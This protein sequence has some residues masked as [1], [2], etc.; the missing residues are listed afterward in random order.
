[1]YGGKRKAL[2]A[3]QAH[4]DELLVL[5]SPMTKA[6]YAAIK[7]KNNRSGLPGVCRYVAVE[8][9]GGTTRARAYWIAFWT[10]SEGRPVHRKFSISKFGEEAAFSRAKAA[11]QQALAALV[12]FWGEG[13]RTLSPDGGLAS[14]AEN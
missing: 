10:T 7:R 8:T 3:A 12:G 5:H 1:M 11:R 14:D 6:E 13:A 9:L 4:R 2:R